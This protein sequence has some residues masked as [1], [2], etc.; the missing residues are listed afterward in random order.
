[1]KLYLAVG[2]GTEPNGVFDPG[3]VNSDGTREYDLAFAV[4]ARAAIALQ[5]CGADFDVET[6]GGPGHDPDYRGSIDRVNAGGFDLALEVHF[7]EAIAPEGGFGIYADDHSLGRPLA[8]S[9]HAQWSAAGLQSRTSYA[10]NRGLGFLQATNCPALIWECGPVH[11]YSPNTL[12]TMGEAIAA[13][14]CAELGI[15]YQSPSPVPEGVQGMQFTVRCGR[16]GDITVVDEEGAAFAYDAFGQPKGKFLGGL[17]GH[18]EWHAGG[19]EAN[20]P[21][22][23]AAT[24]PE[25][26]IAGGVDAQYPN[27]HDG[28]TMITQDSDGNRHFYQFNGDGRYAQVDAPEA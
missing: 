20:G 23:G 19:K 5:R 8:D 4:V 15:E 13:G 22:V 7:D 2:H 6:A 9:I 24:W 26:G 27:G 3:A 17:N 28:L 11:E 12:A 14:L 16:S 1:M 18:P 21:V 25:G 10:D